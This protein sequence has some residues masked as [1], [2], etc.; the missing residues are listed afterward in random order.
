MKVNTYGDK[1][2]EQPL[3]FALKMILKRYEEMTAMFYQES[4]E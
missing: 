3:K 1:S 2:T 4:W